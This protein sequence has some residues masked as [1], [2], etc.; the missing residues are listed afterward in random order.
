MIGRWEVRFHV[1]PRG[2]AP[3]DVVVVD[4]VRL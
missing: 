4:R 1:T 2:A 3:F